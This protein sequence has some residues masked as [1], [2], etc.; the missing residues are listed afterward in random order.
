MAIDLQK[1]CQLADLTATRVTSSYQSWTDFLITAARLYKYPYHE[2]LLIYAQRPDAT[3]CAD[4]DLWNNRMGRYIRRGSQSIALIDYSG[5]TPKLKY[6]FD[7]A[8]TGKRERSRAPY[9]WE[10][11]PEHESVV[12]AALE[13]QFLVANNSS[14]QEQL[15]QIT[16]M[17]VTEYWL[18]RQQ[19]ILGAVDGSNLKWYYDYDKGVAFLNAATVSATYILLSRC[20]LDANTFLARRTSSRSLT[21]IPPRR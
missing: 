11:R 16:S 21:S 7:V 12:S 20:G 14:F 1:Y 9:L 2:Q 3:A 8:D 13:E 15:H 19:D 10:Y 6:V 4:Y 18:A 17:K 5:D